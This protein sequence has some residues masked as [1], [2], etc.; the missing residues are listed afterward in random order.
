MAASWCERP[1]SRHVS[2]VFPEFDELARPVKHRIH[3]AAVAALH[4]SFRPALLAGVSRAIDHPAISMP[5]GMRQSSGDAGRLN[6]YAKKPGSK[7]M[8]REKPS[9]W[10]LFSVDI[11]KLDGFLA[12]KF[13][14]LN[15]TWLTYRGLCDGET[16]RN[17]D[18][19]G[20]DRRSVLAL[21]YLR[22]TAMDVPGRALT[23]PR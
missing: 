6:A 20:Q 2:T 17:E 19:R 8:H 4:I 21:L 9:D 18:Q 12:P 5:S 14:I 16:G 10:R 11:P 13:H 23:G 1:R 3:H 22:W 7:L 15:A